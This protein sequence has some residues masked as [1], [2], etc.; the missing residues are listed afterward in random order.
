M[1]NFS[2]SKETLLVQKKEAEL[3][4][5]KRK[6][7]YARRCFETRMKCIIGGTFHKYFPEAYLFDQNEWCRIIDCVVVSPD[8]KAIVN[9]ILKSE[10]ELCAQFVAVRNERLKKEEMKKKN[11]KCEGAN[12]RSNDPDST[13]SGDEE[14]Y[15]EEQIYQSEGDEEA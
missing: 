10:P 1:R 6:E 3:R 2:V 7:S 12:V 4:E 9:K 15:E 8:F 11:A 14:M 13:D 5:A